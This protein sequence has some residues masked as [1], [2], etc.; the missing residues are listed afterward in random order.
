MYASVNQPI[1]KSPPPGNKGEDFTQMA[2][3]Q[4]RP[5]Q[6]KRKRPT[7][8]FAFFV[9]L[10]YG[11]KRSET[12]RSRGGGDSPPWCPRGTATR[13]RIAW[14]VGYARQRLTDGF[15][16]RTPIQLALLVVLLWVRITKAKRKAPS[17][18]VLFLFGSGGRIRTHVLSES[19]SD[20][21]PLGDT[22]I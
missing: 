5:L 17:S 20:A 6:H 22:R 10:S 2:V 16:M 19:E 21:L 11:S 9:S 18:M 1:I 8:F 3:S 4:L 13:V 14:V 7:T 15:A 12:D